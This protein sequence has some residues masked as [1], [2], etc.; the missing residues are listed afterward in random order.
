MIGIFDSWFGGLQTLK[1]LK[2]IL[3]AYDYLFFA[4]TKNN[5]YGEKKISEVKELTFTALNYLFDQWASLVILA[6]NTASV[7]SI[8]DRQMQF[9]EKKVLS[10]TI[11]GVESLMGKN[12]KDI[13]VLS[14]ELTARSGIY[15]ELY[16]K[17]VWEDAVV[18]NIAAWNL[19]TAIEQWTITKDE[20][21]ILI[22][23]Y[24]DK[25]SK[26]SDCL[27][28]GCTHYSV[29]KEEFAE[30][31]DGSIIDPSYLSALALKEYL[32]K[33]TDIHKKIWKNSKIQICTSWNVK[34]F[35]DIW[36]VICWKNIDVS[37]VTL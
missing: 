35:E 2:E 34:M 37:L 32:Q 3:P 25:V 7:A 19:V 20:R 22:Q 24:L 8:R 16:K 5:P 14:T 27:V 9:P 6:C 18:K 36:S 11:P 12:Y 26:E 17:I 10:V 33:H 31:F 29:W 28:L 30:V 4:D 21:L 13:A 23:N 15:N 1:Y